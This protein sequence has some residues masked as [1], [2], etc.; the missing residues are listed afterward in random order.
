PV[1]KGLGGLGELGAVAEDEVEVTLDGVGPI[2]D[3]GLGGRH[4]THGEGLH[5]VVH[6]GQ[7]GIADGVGV[8]GHAGDD[9]TGGGQLVLV[10]AGILG[11]GDGLKAVPGAGTGLTADGHDLTVTAPQLGPVGDLAGEDLGDLLDGQV[12]HGIVGVDDDG[13]AVLGHGDL[14][15]AG[16]VVLEVT[17]GQADV[18]GAVLGGGDAG[19]GAG[20]GVLDLY[21]GLDLLEGLDQS[22]H[23]ALHGGGAVGHHRAGE[24][25]LLSGLSPGGRSGALGVRGV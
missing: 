23:D 10:L 17:A 3:S 4:L 24:L 20:A 12:G 16:L 7:G 6:G 9:L 13:D 21:V 14:L 25:G 11:A 19:A 22:P 15:H 18:G 2:Q 8:G 1:H 5:G